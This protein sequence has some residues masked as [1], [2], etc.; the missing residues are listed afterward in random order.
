M[1]LMSVTD[2]TFHEDMSPVNEVAWLNILAVL[3]TDDT[4]Q[5]DK[6]ELKPKA[7]SNMDVRSVAP[8][9]SHPDKSPLNDAAEGEREMA[10]RKLRSSTSEI[11]QSPM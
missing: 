2:E 9:T 11:H 8:E 4:S 7:P 1:P 6:S 3:V 5:L 10:N